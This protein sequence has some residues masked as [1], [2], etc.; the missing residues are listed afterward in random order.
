MLH[1]TAEKNMYKSKKENIVKS[2]T[3]L[4]FDPQGSKKDI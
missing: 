4:G 2:F 1:F 3:G